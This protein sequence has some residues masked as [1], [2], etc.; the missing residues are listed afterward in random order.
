M[1][2]RNVTPDSSLYLKNTITL[3]AALT[4]WIKVF[5]F[6]E[7]NLIET[8]DLSKTKCIHSANNLSL[9]LVKLVQ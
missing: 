6:K 2:F 9:I 7:G 4:A 8:V 3:L 5:H 1:D